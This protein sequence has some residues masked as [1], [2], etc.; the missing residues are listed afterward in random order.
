MTSSFTD[1]SYRRM[2][3]PIPW[4]A[5]RPSGRF[6]QNQRAGCRIPGCALSSF[7]GTISIAR[8]CPVLRVLQHVRTSPACYSRGPKAIDWRANSGSCAGAG[9]ACTNA[10]NITPGNVRCEVSLIC[11]DGILPGNARVDDVRFD[12]PL[13]GFRDYRARPPL[14]RLQ[15]LH[16][17]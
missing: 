13:A 11:R 5:A 1:G 9:A 15:M 12:P 6:R 3:P 2:R 7:S 8:R 14:N 4:R 17:G 10:V 16:N